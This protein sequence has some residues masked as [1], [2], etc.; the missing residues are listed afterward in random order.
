MKLGALGPGDETVFVSC[1]KG[2]EHDTGKLMGDILE[3]RLPANPVAVLSGPNH[4][5]K[6]R[7]VFRRRE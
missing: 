1:T 5:A 2:I 7:S 6:S 4:A 3:E